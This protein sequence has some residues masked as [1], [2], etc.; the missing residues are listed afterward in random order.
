MNGQTTVQKVF[1]FFLTKIIIGIGVVGGVVAL[2]ENSGRPLID[3]IPIS[4]DLKNVIIGIAAA[5]LAL[6]SYILLFKFYEKRE[7]KEL[8]PETFWK[9]ALIGFFLGLILQSLII[10][11]MYLAGDYSITGIN[12]ISFLLPGFTQALDAGFVAEII[13]VGI[14]FRLTEE[15]LGTAITLIIFILLFAIMHSGAKGATFLSVVS[16]A[17]QAGILLPAAFIFSRTLWLPIFFHFAWD[18][19]EP[20]IFGGINPGMGVEKSL[21]ISNISGSGILTGGETGPQNS[22]QG[23]IFCLIAAI[24]F[25]QLAK[26]KNNFIKPYWKK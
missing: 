23:A 14:V 26:Q 18:F 20:A 15:K 6:L 16:T 24:I 13:L 2:V 1:H 9:N 19:A 10:L 4:A 22:I 7:V 25:F 11:V 5:V 3:K 8:S 17:I 21:F 12:P